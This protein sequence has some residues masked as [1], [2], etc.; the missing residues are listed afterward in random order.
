MAGLLSFLSDIKVE[1]NK[2]I[3]GPLESLAGTDYG[4]STFR[5]PIDLGSSDKNH[6]VFI[7]ILQQNST[8]FKQDDVKQVGAIDG[9]LSSGR[10]LRGGTEVVEF[11]VN[12]VGEKTAGIVNSVQAAVKTGNQAAQT[13]GSS[14]E[15]FKKE[16]SKVAD[17]LKSGNGVRATSMIKSAIALYMPDTLTFD[18]KQSYSGIG[19][20]G[21][22][23]A[24]GAAGGKSLVDAFKSG[25]YSNLPEN[26]SPF[27]KQAAANVIGQA[28]G[29]GGG[30][31]IFSAAT[32]LVQN[33]M[34]ELVYSSP[35]FITFQLDFMFY[36][37][38]EREARIVQEII[39]EIKYH[40]APEVLQSSN[41]F[42]MVPPSE[43]LVE[44]YYNGE[45]NP[46]L[47][48]M[49]TCILTGTQVNYSPGG[50]HAYEVEGENNPTLG[51][52]GTPVATQLTLSF[53]QTEI[54][55]KQSYAKEY[56][57]SI[58]NGSRT[59]AEIEASQSLADLPRLPRSE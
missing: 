48:Q 41:G 9:G 14:I 29:P 46:N 2:N 35:D 13:V 16:I 1:K 5:Y 26:L 37:R 18:E 43:F 32:G 24:M 22:L 21:S 12:K 17:N 58:R 30:Q 50:F 6:Y 4:T 53:S 56:G 3:R 40:Q 19:I 45:R 27:V 15:S 34:I 57:R 51:G 28:F 55:T 25:D 11:L 8:Q 52:T 38:S 44:F 42:F 7:N 20:G 59:Q 23:G 31:L 36:P 10:S 47:P 39:Q 49:G 54:R 33:P